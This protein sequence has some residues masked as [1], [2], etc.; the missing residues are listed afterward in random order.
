MAEPCRM[1]VL[2]IKHEGCFLALTDLASVVSKSLEHL[3]G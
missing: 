2:A 1:P 3:I